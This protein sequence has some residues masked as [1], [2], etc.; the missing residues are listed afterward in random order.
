[1]SL[2]DILSPFSAWKNLALEPV[3]VK[4]PLNER[5]GA[6]RY[7][8]FHKN[9]L[10]EC[11]G[12][13]TCSDICQNAAIDM[14]PVEGI[15]TKAGDSGLRPMI[16]YGRCCW[17][18]LC[19]D[20]CSTNSLSLSNEYTWVNSDPEVFRFIPGADKKSWDANE[21]GWK[22]PDN[23]NL[24]EPLRVKMEET[25]PDE[26]EMSFLEVV[27]GY[28]KEQAEA[29]ADRC[30]ECG[31]C[32]ATCPAHMDIPQYIKTIRDNNLEEGLRIMYQTN[33]LPEICGRVCTRRCETVC[34][35][36]HK[37]DAISIR[38]LK[39]YIADNVSFDEYEKILNEGFIEKTDK[40][41]S[42]IGAGPSGLSLGY[43]LTQRGIKA[44]IYEAKE[45]AGGMTMYGIPKYRLPMEILDKE[46]EFLQKI[47]VEIKFNTAVGKNI[48]FNDLYN[49]SD[50]VFIG[51]GFESPY[52]I[53]IEGENL[54]GSLQAIE[55]LREINKG[56]KIDIGKKAVIVGGGNVAIDAARIAKR[57]GA[58]TTILYRRRVEDMPADWEEI[59]GAEDEKVNIITQAIP[60][61]I[62]PD[63]KGKVKAVKYLKAKMVADDKGGRPRP[64]PIEG[65]E[66]II[67]TETVIG[68]I[69]QGADYSFLPKEFEEKLELM[70][71]RI[72]TD[73]NM[74]TSLDKVFAGGDAVNRT[75]DA[76]SAIADGHK[77]AI[78]IEKML[79][80][81]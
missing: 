58:E 78:G 68:A 31:L 71:G 3:T 52:K 35:L 76:I 66:T 32:T 70:R 26:R 22:K 41:V 51:V 30:I 60:V 28:S 74:K 53:G 46:V 4:D 36:G 62:I 6:P 18:A 44:T 80:S 2:K 27:K 77:A 59:E 7:R 40:K 64:V 63:E 42:I 10:N 55:F 13:G 37:G 79:L 24:N 56:N 19:V 39:R 50:A 47:G 15:E 73:S 49:N 45:K 72:V 43:Y 65:S 17:C 8:G 57:I 14:V 9:E 25:A 29:E 81:E 21:L 12:C 75:A 67:E 5:P 20:I 16:D 54:K 61:E 23:Y 34:A 38:W 48:S 33:P 11:I 1:M 69:G